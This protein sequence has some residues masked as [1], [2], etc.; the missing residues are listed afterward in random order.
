MPEYLLEI[1]TEEIPAQFMPK[2]IQQL[3]ELTEEKLQEK[4]IKYEKVLALGT[5]RRLALLIHGLATKG[6]DLREEV[7][8]PA[9]RAAY[10]PSGKLTKAAEGFAR[11]QGVR[12]EDLYVKETENG[13]YVFALRELKGLLAEEILPELAVQVITGLSFPKP[14]RWGNKEMRFARPIRWLV[15]LL[16]DKIISFKIEGLEAGRV[17]RGHRFYGQEQIIIAQLSTYLEQLEKEFVIV[18][19]QKRK[20]KCRHQIQEAAQSFGGRVDKDEKLLEEI[21]HLVEWPTAVTGS[22]AP[23]YL[24]LPEEVVITPMR[25]HQRYF[26]VRDEDGNLKNRFIT[27]RNGDSN[28]LEIVASG[29]EKVLK[30][31]LADARFFWEEDQKLKLV[32][33]L[34]RLE[35]I[36]FQE[37]LGTIAEKITRIEENV[38]VLSQKLQVKAG[39][40]EQALRAA[41]LSKADL[42]TNMVYEFPELQG[43]MGQYYARLSGESTEVAQA[44]LE[45][46]QPRFANDKIP[47]TL[48]G[49]LVSIAD[50]MDTIAG[51]FAIGIEPTGSQDPYALRRQAMG[52][53]QIIIGHRLEISLDELIKKALANY[54]QVLSQEELG[55]K[56]RIKIKEF[57]VS[58]LK[59]IL[60]DAGYAH[61]IIEAVISV[62]ND[63]LLMTLARAEAL[64]KVK[65]E[66]FFEEYVTA[67][68][69]VHNLAKK[70]DSVN[71]SSELFVEEIEAQLYR[72]VQKAMLKSKE[73]KA[74]YNFTG[75]LKEL[76]LLT[77]PIH[78]FFESLM[79]MD[80]DERIRENRLA[81]LK[82]IVLLT[83][84]AGDLSKIEL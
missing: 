64:G 25:E 72:I 21:T 49:A 57:F 79:V 37:R 9:K 44:I 58:R 29:N 36:V 45:H 8:G 19:Q 6:E 53:C 78:T 73:M 67:F 3:K 82:Q 63:L 10:D 34:P 56:T 31:R 69:R 59:N 43:I 1:G 40:K 84:L 28:N 24:S 46:Y 16:D 11:S 2:A 62:E 74:K 5:P 77:Q 54:E 32:D 70:A 20:E 33:Y 55:E 75:I 80:K 22:F 41:L 76:A 83:F 39:V 50:K 15:S 17:S 30:A 13:E 27:I 66:V 7:R 23:E 61:D 47:E 60:Q 4:R 12:T 68:I 35:K 14:M 52:V 18:D 42:V 51:C 65:E 71:V 26:P 81:L 48:E 38:R